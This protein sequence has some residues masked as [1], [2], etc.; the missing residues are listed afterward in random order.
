MVISQV[1][2]EARLDGEVVLQATGDAWQMPSPHMSTHVGFDASCWGDLTL[3]HG[4]HALQL[5]FPAHD[6][7]GQ[8]TRLFVALGELQ[9]ARFQHPTDVAFT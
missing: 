2:I 6:R 4:Q 1:P 5:R 8:P 9:G 7:T 3:G